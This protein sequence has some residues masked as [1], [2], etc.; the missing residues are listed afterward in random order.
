[1]RDDSITSILGQTKVF[2]NDDDDDDV[3]FAS[4]P[5]THLSRPTAK[6][7]VKG[8]AS[9][10]DIDIDIDIDINIHKTVTY[11]PLIR[12]VRIY[13]KSPV[14]STGA[15]LVDLPGTD[16]FGSSTARRAVAE[17]YMTHCDSLWM[18]SPIDR[19]A[20][21]KVARHFFSHSLRLQL[22]LDGAI[23]NLSFVYTKTDSWPDEQSS[24]SRPNNHNHNHNHNHIYNR[25][26]DARQE[27]TND[28]AHGLLDI[29]TATQHDQLEMM[30]QAGAAVPPGAGI[31]IEAD[32]LRQH[33]AQFRRIGQRMPVFCV[34]ARAYQEL[35]R[36]AGG[37][38]DGFGGVGDTEIVQLQRHCVQLTEKLRRLAAVR[39]LLCVRQLLTL[40]SMWGAVGYGY[41]DVQVSGEEKVN[42]EGRFRMFFDMFEKVSLG[43]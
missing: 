7:D 33:S 43:P 25:N 21:E 39:F 2:E 6:V 9:M 30:I 34:S 8:K 31:R 18:V 4:S 38:V 12:V 10:R 11:S 26:E 28:F 1:M 17:N 20:D 35:R 24:S 16:S 13:L 15:A 29:Y 3:C 27:L 41:E 36:G 5:A 23:E 14:L 40:V 19:A 42:V 22:Y 37:P 32:I